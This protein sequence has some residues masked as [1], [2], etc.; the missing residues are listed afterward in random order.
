MDV[1]AGFPER[2]SMRL[3]WAGGE[4]VLRSQFVASHF[5][6]SVAAA[7][8]TAIELGVPLDRI[9]ERIASFVPIRHRCGMIDVPG[10]PHFVVDTVK[11]PW[12]SLPLAFDIVAAA[13]APRKR[14][15]LGHMSDFAGS[16]AKYR[17]AY[18]QARPI[19]DQT[20]FVGE[21]SHRSKASREDIEV[22]RFIELDSPLAVAN[23]LKATA[24]PGE[25]ILLKGSSNLHLERVAMSFVEDVRCWVPA[26]GKT[27]GCDSCGLF[28]VPYE[29]HRGRRSWRQRA[30][31][32]RLTRPWKKARRAG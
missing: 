7:A 25:L 27:Q 17:D 2:L 14:I 21:H 26:C 30:L 10:G 24:M 22:G 8:A 4:L 31:L 12:H 32:R 11:A 9:A 28:A 5:W 19:A 18:R 23:H 16:D 3:V 13:R 29:L 15:V 20:V 6:L 1:E